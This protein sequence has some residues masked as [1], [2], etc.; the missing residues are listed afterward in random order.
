MRDAELHPELPGP[1]VPL[2]KPLTRFRACHIAFREGRLVTSYRTDGNTVI[3]TIR[4]DC[5]AHRGHTDCL[6]WYALEPA[7]HRAGNEPGA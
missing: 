7:E 3:G 1:G 6:R 5:P 2:F 4:G